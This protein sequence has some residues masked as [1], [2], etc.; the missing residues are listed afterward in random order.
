MINDLAIVAAGILVMRFIDLYWLIVPAF[1]GNQLTFHWLDVAAPVAIGGIWMMGFIRE[2]K[3]QPLVPLH[4]PRFVNGQ[5]I[6][7]H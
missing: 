7:Q 5:S 6:Y 3:G 1:S 2:L 4:D